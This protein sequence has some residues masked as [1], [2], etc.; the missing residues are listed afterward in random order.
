MLAWPRPTL[1]AALL[2]AL[3]AV[4]CAS[5]TAAA[6]ADLVRS[7]PADGATLSAAP[8]EVHLWF[9]EEIAPSF[10]AVQVLD[11]AG[12]SVP[13]VGVHPDPA[14]R[15]ALV[16]VLPRLP[17]GAYT[18]I[19][20]TLSATDGH[21]SQG[22]V[23]FGVNT[24]APMS[25]AAGAEA[26][27]GDAALSWPEVA[28]RWLN[29]LGLIGLTGAL[30]MGRFVHRSQLHNPA[31]DAD[32][33]WPLIQRRLLSMAAWCAAIALLAGCALLLRQVA[34]SVASASAATASTSWGAAV[35]ALLQTRW[36]LL[37][38]ARQVLLLVLLALTAHAARV[39]TPENG[40]RGH[41]GVPPA[42]RRAGWTGG[43]SGG[44]ADY[45]ATGRT[46]ASPPRLICSR[47]NPL[48][49]AQR[50]TVLLA[51]L[52]IIQA[53]MGHAAGDARR[54]WIAVPAIALHL[55]AAGVWLGGL[56]ALLVGWLP[57]LRRYPERR[58]ELLRAGLRP[59]GP[60]AAL[61]VA[62]LVASGLFSAGQQ[63]PSLDALVLT[64]YGRFLLGKAG[65]LLVAGLCGLVNAAL[66]R[67]TPQWAFRSSWRRLPA[68]IGVELA[69]GAAILLLTGALTAGAPPR[70]FA[71]T[72]APEDERTAMTQSVDDLQVTLEIK[73]SHPGQNVFSVRSAS[74]LDPPPAQITRVWLQFTYLDDDLGRV[75]AR[76]EEVAPGRY[77]LNGDFL[78]L[79]GPWRIDVITRRHGIEDSIAQFNWIV[80]PAAPLP[81]TL[82]SK[83][84][85]AMPLALAALALLLLTATIALV[86]RC[87]P[88][89]QPILA[90]RRLRRLHPD[91][92][93]DRLP[94]R[95]LPVDDLTKAG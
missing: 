57:L 59:F 33:D 72:L 52:L 18:L 37:W 15:S 27:A 87:R 8:A 89:L 25:A 16:A 20:K 35:L 36:G 17:A 82:L 68:L 39:V 64:S 13:G 62:L 47:L 70:G 50:L 73:P 38:L 60:V 10:S 1:F 80:T 83:Q 23:L 92:T 53:L 48:G 78:K 66:L 14:Q 21:P 88:R 76:A 86:V 94:Q 22:M 26:V 84:P 44:S 49:A 34:V 43:A 67:F 5:R 9:S 4:L 3:L 32:I 90:Q 79:A 85:L 40:T 28:I 24:A 54:A 56:A 7:E 51:T 29:Y 2:L 55:L 6:H 65:L 63:V 30:V 75:K 81:P 91:S 11:A 95:P 42:R 77:L 71:F 69:A 41:V 31:Q 74:K 45:R 58:G 46:G 61:A 12:Q 93:P 19:W